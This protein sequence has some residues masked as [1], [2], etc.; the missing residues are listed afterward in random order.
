MVIIIKNIAIRRNYNQHYTTYFDKDNGLLI[1]KEDE[2]YPEPFWS[3]MG[4]ELLDI[5]ITNWCDEYC[6]ICYR[7]SNESG[8]NMSIENYAKIIKEASKIGVLQVAL[9]GGN[10][11]QHPQF[12]EILKLT[13]HKYGI[14]PSYTSNGKGF[15]KKILEYSK[16]YCGAVAI[17]FSSKTNIMISSIKKLKSFGVKTNIHFVLTKDSVVDA[18]HLLKSKSDLLTGINAIIFLN[19]KSIGKHANNNSLL[20]YSRNIDVF[21]ELLRT[22][23]FP[24]KIGFD[25]CSISG[26]N[27]YLSISKELLEP[28]EAGRFSA[29]ISEDLRMYPCSFMINMIKGEKLD[30]R[31]IK[32]IWLKCKTFNNIREKINTNNY[33]GEC[34][35]RSTC[36]EG[37]PIF[38][39]INLC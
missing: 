8:I 13:R 16:E 30:D 25:S 28:C 23:S 31:G 18:I 36:L 37:C 1:R 4:P 20:K 34:N 17:S 24:Y 3:K 22:K 7:D 38:P 10:P 5:S 29:F 32:D 12:C 2:G 19:Y 11:N 33:C 27:K 9:G 26:I 15:S 14:V 6:S 21:F 35:Q 39:E